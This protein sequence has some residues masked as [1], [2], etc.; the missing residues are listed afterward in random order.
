MYE[1]M[2]AGTRTDICTAVFTI[3]K[4]QKVEAAQPATNG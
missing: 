3:H 2:K 4:S 1:E